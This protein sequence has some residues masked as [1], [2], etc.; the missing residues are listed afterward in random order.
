MA[1]VQKVRKLTNE[2]PLPKKRPQRAE[3]VRATPASLMSRALETFGS[4]AKA[5]HWLNRPNHVFQGKTPL[6]AFKSNPAEVETE[7]TRID[8][9]VYI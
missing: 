5:T 4:E 2:D 7:L 3:P 1:L 8:H 6:Q 9:G